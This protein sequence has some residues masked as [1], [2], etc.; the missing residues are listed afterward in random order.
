MNFLE[1]LVSEWYEYQRY[2]IIRNRTLNILPGGGYEGEI[3]I[4]AYNPNNDEVIHI[5]TS[6]DSKDWSARIKTFK[7]KFRWTI[8]EYRN[9]FGLPLSVTQINKM[10]VVSFSANPRGDT[11]IRFERETGATLIT[12]PKLLTMIVN[13]LKNT[14]QTGLTIP[15]NLHM[16]R[17]IQLAMRHGGL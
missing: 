3:D 13:S 7:E 9:V 17:A 10:A 12:V 5:E 14:L 1:E 4:L 2:F 6:S 15:E 16:L 8:E 11:K